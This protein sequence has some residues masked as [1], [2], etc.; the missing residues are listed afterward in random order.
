MAR[1]ELRSGPATLILA[2]ELGGSIAALRLDGVDLLRPMA[3][4]AD[5]PLHAACFPLVPYANRISG[6]RVEFKGRT[7]KLAPNMPGQPHPLHGDGWLS[8]WRVLCSAEASLTLDFSPEATEWPWRYHAV[9]TFELAEDGLTVSLSVRNISEREGLF[10][11]GLHPYFPNRDDACLTARLRG[12]W[13]TNLENL[14]TCH[15][16]GWPLVDWRFGAAIASA[17]LID[18]THTGWD[19]LAH[20][21]LGHGHPALKVTASPAL[22]CLHVY[23]PPGEAF[24]CVEPVSGVLEPTESRSGC[25]LGMHQ[26]GPQES[27]EGWMRLTWAG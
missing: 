23:S 14:P 13:L 5:S 2:P 9:Q 17:R 21:D 3:E 8:P 7:S 26:L 12:I 27:V 10:G 11:L 1:L 18:H 22:S 19:G 6:G 16:E 25:S 24:F 15:V 20:I 4:N